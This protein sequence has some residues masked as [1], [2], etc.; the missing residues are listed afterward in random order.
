MRKHRI[1]PALTLFVLA[2]A[3]GELLSGSSPPLEFFNPLALLFMSSL[4]GSGAIVCRELKIRWKKG[5]T[6]LLLLGAAYGILEE[7]L[8]V[9]SFFDP[10]WVDLGMLGL[11]GRWAQV[12]WV[13]TEMLTIYHAVFSIA[14]PIV[15]VELVF[16]ERKNDNWI[17]KRAFAALVA[18]LA[19]VATI[20]FLFLTEYRPPMLQYSAAVL[21]MVLF[22]YA[23]YM[24]PHHPHVNSIQTAGKPK[25]AF[26]IGC[27]GS[28]AFFLLFWAGPH[29][30]ES[31]I[32][33]MLLGIA[34]VFGI[35]KLLRRIDLRSP[36][37]AL[38]RLAAVAGA[39]SFL[40]F[41]GFMIELGALSN[42]AL[43]GMAFV[44]IGAIV[45]LGR[46][47]NKAKKGNPQ[48]NAYIHR[49]N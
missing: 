9:K 1:P 32:I 16:P 8:M 41:L 37:A 49:S 19:L 22:V 47:R 29:M 26:A 14:I 15:L 43:T 23:A 28:A 30:I 5:C 7:G 36:E 2:P 33:V 10:N 12:N 34:L 38:N 11:Y 18:L 17:G 31:P 13:W 39:L 46:L 21:A 44:S 42:G 25:R 4:Y 45:E 20:G 24:I 40:I 27:I 6:S 35:A 3:I 48:V